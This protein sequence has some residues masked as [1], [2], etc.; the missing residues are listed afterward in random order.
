MKRSQNYMCLYWL[1]YCMFTT[2]III[3]LILQHVYAH[4]TSCTK[5]KY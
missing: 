5:L 3:I 1:V 4:F 2:K